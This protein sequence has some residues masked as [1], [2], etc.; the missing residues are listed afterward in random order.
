LEIGKKR[1]SR[2]SRPIGVL[3][4]ETSSMLRRWYW[5]W[6]V[7][8]QSLGHSQKIWPNPS[9]EDTTVQFNYLPTL[10]GELALNRGDT[11]GAI[12]SLQVTSSHEL[13][14]PNGPTIDLVMLPVFVR[15]KACLEP[16]QRSEAAAEFQKI[17]DRQGLLA[18]SPIRA[19]ANLYLARA[20][21]PQSNSLAGAEAYAARAKARAAYEGFLTLWKDAD[22]N[23]PIL[24]EAKAEYAKLQ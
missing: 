2:F 19:L 10:H 12:E 15:G 11:A 7:T 24:N 8:L 23:I 6:L 20:Y 4:A 14:I 17:L 21:T 9:P 3:T 22:P 13:M 16:N 5:R 1:E 18:F